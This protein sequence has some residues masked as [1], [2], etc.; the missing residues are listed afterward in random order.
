MNEQ[1]IQSQIKEMAKLTLL[2]GRISEIQEKNLK[3]LPFV[4]FNG[5]RGI[6]IDYDLSKQEDKRKRTFVSYSLDI[7]ET[8]ENNELAKRFKILESSVRNLFWSDLGV[9]VYFNDKLVYGD[10]HV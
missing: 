2:S 5:L 6:Q 4:F 3:S 1:E 10:R 9:S 8:E 7:D